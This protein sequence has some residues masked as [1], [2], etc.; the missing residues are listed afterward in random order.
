MQNK[1]DSH[2]TVAAGRGSVFGQP[3]APPSCWSPSTRTVKNTS[4][5]DGGRLSQLPESRSTWPGERR[6]GRVA[7][8]PAPVRSADGGLFMRGSVLPP[9]RRH[10]GRRGTRRGRRGS[11][12]CGCTHDRC[13]PGGPPE[14]RAAMDGGQPRRRRSSSPTDYRTFRRGGVWPSAKP[15]LTGGRFAKEVTLDTTAS[16]KGHGRRRSRA[17]CRRR[18]SR[19]EAWLQARRG[20]R[21]TAA[22]PQTKLPGRNT[23]HQRARRSTRTGLVL[24]LVRGWAASGRSPRAGRDLRTSPSGGAVAPGRLPCRTRLW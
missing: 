23:K 14:G 20:P 8:G 15:Y 22:L 18:S 7:R 9:W 5:P 16:L 4:A 19:H 11:A 12:A 21:R 17:W 2:G 3:G 6:L 10:V 13:G 24:T 1:V